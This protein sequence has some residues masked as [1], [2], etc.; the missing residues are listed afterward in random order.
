MQIEELYKLYLA[1]TG[2][3]TDTRKIAKGNLFFAL[4]GDKFN[5]NEFAETALNKGAAYVIVDELVEPKW[6]KKYGARF[7]LL[8]NVLRTLQQLAGYHRQQLKC[9]VLAIT[10]SNGKTTTKELIA[11]VLSKKYKTFATKG[12][13]NNHIGV[14]LTLLSIKGYS[15]EFAVIEMGANHQGEIESYCEY[16]KPDY[17]LITNIGSAHLEGFGGI[18]GVLKGKT[19]LYRDIASRNGQV[20]IN[21]ESETLVSNWQLAIGNNTNAITYGKAADAYCK[22]EIKTSTE[23]LTVV[24]EGVEI[25]TNLVGDYNFENVMSA[26]CVGKY[27]GVE[28]PLIKEAIENYT[29]TNNRSQ[30]IVEGTTTIILDAYNA[31][32]SSMLEA[33]KNFEKLEAENKVAILGQMMELGE[34]SRAEHE[35]IFAATE[36]L[37]NTKRVFVG[38]GFEFVNQLPATRSIKWFETTEDL[39]AWYRQQQ[40]ENTS[41]LIK[42][43]R[44]NELEKIL[45]A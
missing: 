35:K 31:N 43:S 1:S 3:T 5:A 15:A 17:G 41:I 30:K 37:Q 4:K 21:S 19:E 40:F 7:I 20:F 24:T 39:A 25:K 34:Y 22:G 10:G 45:Q 27:F 29:P 12:N 23:F 11:A 8:R 44:K 9:P 14:P 13:L 33:I 42:G 38:A 36:N 26:I 28:L 2:I 18:E 32:P 6:K 16:T